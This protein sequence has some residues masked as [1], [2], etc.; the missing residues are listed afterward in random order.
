MDGDK[1]LLEKFTDTLKAAAGAIPHPTAG[2][3]MAMPLNESGY[4]IT[5]LRLSST[6]RKKTTGKTAVKPSAKTA[7]RKAAKRSTKKSAA[8]QKAAKPWKSAAKTG[9][10][11]SAAKKSASKVG[12]KKRASKSRR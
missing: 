10:K 11:K 4:A 2:T 3:P 6:A 12:T 1:S 9:G 8:K 5:H 7:S